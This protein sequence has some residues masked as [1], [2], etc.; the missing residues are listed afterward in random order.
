MADDSYTLREVAELLGVSKRSL[1]RR[2]QEGAFPNRFLRPGR[3]GLETRIPA[4]DVRRVMEEIRR[5]GREQPRSTAMSVRPR[6][7][8]RALYPDPL[9]NAVAS[10]EPDAIDHIS[11]SPI[12]ENALTAG[13]LDSLRETMLST[14]RE[15]REMFLAAVRS[16]LT[17]RDREIAGLK[18]EVSRMRD[19]M[20]NVRSG[21]ERLER[22]VRADAQREADAELQEWVEALGT[23]SAVDA[24]AVLRE[25]GELESILGVLEGD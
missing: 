7:A 8:E 13:D 23:R 1:Q 15:E 4:E 9:D 5:H 20:E 3:H 19:L 25:L 24:E 2:I 17:L 6:P 12:V 14:V 16:A 22:R 10:Y 21:V 18:D 11:S